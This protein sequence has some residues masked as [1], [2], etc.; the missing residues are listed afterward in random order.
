MAWRIGLAALLLAL[1]SSVGARHSFTSLNP[2]KA[3]PGIRIQLVEL[4]PAVSGG[5]VRYSLRTDGFPP[6]VTVGVWTKDFGRYFEELIHPV[7]FDPNGVPIAVG[8]SG[9]QREGKPIE[10]DPGPYPR[11]AAWG[12]ALA[13]DDHQISAFARV[14][15]RPIEARD[16][17][18]TLSLEL[19]SLHGNR[20]VASG[21]GFSPGE[22]ARI[23]LTSSGR[24]AYRVLRVSPDGSLPLDVVSHG[25]VSA[26]LTARYAVTALKCKPVV[27]YQWGEAALKRH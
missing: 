11:G 10:L 3:S 13:S 14:I 25:E 5:T 15:P 21:T 24:T 6:G 18:C 4:P 27:E 8:S 2:R 23:E 19:I 1:S 16:G 12:V 22:S 17:P 7:A 9:G 26:D 20:F